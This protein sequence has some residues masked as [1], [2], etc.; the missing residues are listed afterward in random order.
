MELTAQE[1][2]H[3]LMHGYAFDNCNEGKYRML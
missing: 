1:I 2:L 3:E